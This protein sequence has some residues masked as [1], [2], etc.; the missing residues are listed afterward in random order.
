VIITG[1]R[2]TVPAGTWHE[3]CTCPG[4]EQERQAMIEAGVETLEE[5][6]RN[7]P[8][9][10]A[11]LNAA[12]TRAQ[13]KSREQAREIY[14]AE[15]RARGLRIPPERVLDQIAEGLNARPGEVVL[16]LGK[17]LTEMGKALHGIYKMHRQAGEDQR[18]GPQ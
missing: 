14:V 3:S 17:T 16:L 2:L 8:A 1:D 9:R 10:K 6:R 12:R 4:A 18:P 11:A 13:G 5:M 15:L 7:R